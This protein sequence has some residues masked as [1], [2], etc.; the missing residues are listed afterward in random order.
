MRMNRKIE[1][2]MG[3]LAVFSLWQL[4]PSSGLVN[5]LF[6]SPSSDVMMKIYLE[7]FPDICKH[8]DVKKVEKDCPRADSMHEQSFQVGE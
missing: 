4:I 5:P 3:L 7:V 8:D 1:G 2:V 6:F